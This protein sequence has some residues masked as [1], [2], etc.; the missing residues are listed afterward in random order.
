MPFKEVADNRLSVN[1]TSVEFLSVYLHCSYSSGVSVP[2]RRSVTIAYFVLFI[3]SPN[4]HIQIYYLHS[5][6]NTQQKRFRNLLNLLGEVIFNRSRSARERYIKRKHRQI[7][8]KFH[9]DELN[10]IKYGSS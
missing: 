10:G 3:A 6:K 2:G 5:E 4:T 8:R 1:R 7:S 9:N